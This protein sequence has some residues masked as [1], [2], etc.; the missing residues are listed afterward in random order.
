VAARRSFRLAAR[1]RGAGAVA[2]VAAVVLL[3]GCAT[4]SSKL[5]DLRPQL[6]A[7]EYDAALATVQERTGGKD[8]LLAYLESGLLLHY[9]DRW[10]ESNEAFAAA[11]RTGE[12]LYARSISEGAISLFTNDMAISYRARPYEMAMVPYFRALDYAYLGDRD[13]ALV[14]A[15]KTSL[16]LS[17]YVDATI[18][19]IERTD[20]GDLARTRNDPFML[21][22]SGMLYDWDGELNDAFVA[23]RNAATAYQDTHRLLGL[24]IPP[25][26]ARDLARVSARLGFA[27]ELAQLRAACPDVFAAAGEGADT[28]VDGGADGGAIASRGWRPGEGELALLVEVGFVPAREQAKLNLPIFESD[29][30]DDNSY[31]AWELVG[32]AGATYALFEGY[33]IAYW[34]TV[35][36]P[37]LPE[38][39]SPIRTVRAHAAGRTAVGAR[40][41]HPAAS[42]RITFEAEYPTI[43]FKTILRGL[44]KYLAS[45]EVE[46]QS[47]ALGLLTNLLGVATE[48]AD[49]RGWLTLPE[50]IQ[51]VRLSLPEGV[52]DVTVDLVGAGGRDL[53]TVTIP[54]L[55]IRAGDW[56]FHNHRVFDR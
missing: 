31:W 43:L 16:M 2:L 36:V 49:T 23:Y 35:A 12:E 44:A 34:L 7:G 25:S 21:Y 50:H 5:A 37:T 28:S 4:Y 9:A 1:L 41:H 52:H 38:R 11:E 26:L 56:T 27:S 30:Y 32:R 15:R 3:G 45:H 40:A 18:A 19:G 10:A 20:T 22:F 46:K 24:E 6:V 42:A 17:R 29:A 8:V 14:E 39:R 55:D 13:A 51:L 54:G 48:T 47:Q 33:D 53:G